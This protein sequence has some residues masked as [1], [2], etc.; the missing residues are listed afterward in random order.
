MGIVECSMLMSCTVKIAAA[1]A[2]RCGAKVQGTSEEQKPHHK[3]QAAAAAGFKYGG[4]C[5]AVKG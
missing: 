4:N 2:I 5:I 3:S 1:M